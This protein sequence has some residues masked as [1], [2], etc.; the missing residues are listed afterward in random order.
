LGDH[1]ANLDRKLEGGTRAAV[2]NHGFEIIQDERISAQ[3]CLEICTQFS[4]QIDQIQLPADQSDND[5]EFEREFSRA[6]TNRRANVSVVDNYA[7]GDAVQFMVSLN[8][9]ATIVG[10]NRGLGRRTRQ[11]GGNYDG[12]TLR[13]VSGHHAIVPPIRVSGGRYTR[14]KAHSRLDL[15]GAESDAGLR[16]GRRSRGDITSSVQGERKSAKPKGSMS[17]KSSGSL[18]K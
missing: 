2:S 13:T 3:D 9:K 15:E 11:Y 1:L 16:G 17:G 6:R 14:G 12:L 18:R 4:A 8:S 7:V 5:S 10:R